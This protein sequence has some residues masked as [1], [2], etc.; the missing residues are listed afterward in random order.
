MALTS[1]PY[2]GV[3]MGSHAQPL[4]FAWPA[5]SAWSSVGG[6]STQSE[7]PWL[8]PVCPL[9]VPEPE[10]QEQQTEVQEPTPAPEDTSQDV[11]TVTLLLRAPPGGTSSAPASPEPLLEPAAAQ[12]PAAEAPVSSEPLPHS[13]EAPS[14]EPPMSPAP[15]S[16][17]GPVT[18][19]VSWVSGGMP[20]R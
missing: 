2:A 6:G 7:K 20:G 1:L 15:P 10:P 8:H 11:T 3:P 18:S 5:L 14:P 9:Q 4:C 19:K 13:S 12:C 17:Q 16:S